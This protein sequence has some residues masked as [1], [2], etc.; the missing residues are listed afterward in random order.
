MFVLLK[1]RTVTPSAVVLT[2]SALQLCAHMRRGQATE[3]LV[4]GN[5][6][7]NLAFAE[8]LPI[9]A[10]EAPHRL[11][12]IFVVVLLGQ[13]TE[14]AQGEPFPPTPPALLVP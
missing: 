9:G 12:L 4:V 1:Q 6:T 5:L 7:S 14:H 3:I 8:Q 13:S 10:K 2:P 11:P